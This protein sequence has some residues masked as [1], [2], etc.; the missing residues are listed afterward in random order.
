MHIGVHMGQV[1]LLHMLEKPWGFYSAWKLGIDE[2]SLA[3]IDVHE[4]IL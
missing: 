1:L 3:T 4:C 2:A